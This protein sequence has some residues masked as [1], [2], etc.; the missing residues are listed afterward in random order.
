[1]VTLKD[2]AQEAGVS[3]MTVSRV[4]NDVPSRVSE[5]KRAHVKKIIKQLGYVP[6]SSARSLSSRSSKLVAV[7]V[8]DDLIESPYGSQMVGHISPLIQQRDYSPLLYI[9]KDYAYITKQLRTWNV[10]GAVFLGLFDS[11]LTRIQANHQIPLVFIDSYSP[12]RQLTNVGIDDEKGGALAADHIASFGHTEI[13][14]VGHGSDDSPVLNARLKGF[15]RMLEAKGLT[16]PP[17]RILPDAL[18]SVDTLVKL[19]RGDKPVTAFFATSD[20]LALKII[21]ALRAI[22]VRVP[23]DCS[24][25]GFDNLEFGAISSPPL[26]TVGQDIKRKAAFAA[27]LL[28]AKIEN[29]N[30]PAQN[31]TLD[32]ELV[33]R[34]SVVKPSQ[35]SPYAP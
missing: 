6:N 15:Q 23:E 20:Y 19:C 8:K 33:K 22:G 13:V 25:M 34:G 9:V 29:K 3:V 21:S 32:V 17:E 7:L 30:T 11:D 26:T 31:I 35:A 4:I 12:L 24:V 14:F 27:D 1:M 28:F 16:L 5:E 2:I 10:D 18:P